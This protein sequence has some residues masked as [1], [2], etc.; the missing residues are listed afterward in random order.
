MSVA[1]DARAGGQSL[2]LS[3]PSS[4]GTTDVTFSSA[5]IMTSTHSFTNT[6]HCFLFSCVFSFEEKKELEVYEMKDD[7]RRGFC[8]IINNNDFSNSQKEGREGT[9]IDEKSLVDIF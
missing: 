8:L 2:D 1:V 6:A 5:Q 9:D 3:Q 4:S 7:R